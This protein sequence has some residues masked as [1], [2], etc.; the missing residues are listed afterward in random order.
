M[1][2]PGITALLFCYRLP[3]LT[4]QQFRTYVEE[5]HVP[6]VQSL[7]G[8]HHPKTHTRYYTNKDSGFAVGVPTPDDADLIAVITFE[9]TE[10][11]Q[12]SMKARWA[13]GTRD[14]IEEDEGKFMDRGRVKLVVLGDEDVGRSVREG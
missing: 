2:S 1:A 12:R 13:D 3:T 5:T 14:K 6:L 11:M 9:S 10:A 8:A 7:L 4:P